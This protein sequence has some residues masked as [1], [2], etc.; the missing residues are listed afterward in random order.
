MSI[1]DTHSFDQRLVLRSPIYSLPEFNKNFEVETLVHDLVFLEAIYI[2]SPSLH[3]ACIKYRDGKI[4]SEKDIIKF[5]YSLYKY[6]SRMHN[7]CTP[8]GLFS[9]CRLT[10]WKAGASE[11][12]IDNYD[13]RRHTRLDMQYLCKL[14]EYLSTLPAIKNRLLY[15]PNSSWYAIGEEIRYV[16][17]IYINGRRQHQ[18]SSLKSST[19]LL[20]IIE[21][22]K[23][24]LGNADLIS[25]LVKAGIKSEESA[26]FIENCMNSQLL[27]NELDPAVTGDGLLT[28]ILK[29]LNS[30]TLQDQ[31][32]IEIVQTLNKIERLLEELDEQ[33][34]NKIDSY[35]EILKLIDSIGLP[36]EEGKIFQTDVTGA[37]TAN[38][39]LSVDLQADILTALDVLHK[40][41]K[42]NTVRLKLFAKRFY[43][44]YGDKEMPLLK[45]LDTEIGIGYIP[46]KQ[47]IPSPILDNITLPESVDNQMH[48]WGKWESILQKKW[49]RAYKNDDLYIEIF[50]EDIDD[51]VSADLPLPSSLQMM[52]EITSSGQVYIENNGGT[53][54]VN[55]LARFAQ[56]DADINKLVT[57]I[58]NNEQDN[59]SGAILAE[60]V[61]LPEG[62]IGNILQRPA[63][64]DYEIP[65]LAKSLLPEDHQICMQ[66]LFISYRN[67]RIVLY[68]KKLNKIILPRLSNAHNFNLNALPVYYF[69]CDLQD[70]D[71]ISSLKFSWGSLHRQYHFLPRVVY[72][73]I[74][75]R[76]ASWVFIEKEILVLLQKDNQLFNELLLWFIKEYNL[77]QKVVLAEGDNELMIDFKDLK[78]THDIFEH[79]LKGKKYFVFKEFLESAN[80]VKDI[81][82]QHYK[83]QFQAFLTTDSKHK[84][85]LFAKN[86]RSWQ[87]KLELGA[88]SDDSEWLYYK[89]YCGIANADL[90]LGNPVKALTSYCEKKGW[91]EEWFFIRYTD[92][93]FHIRLRLKLTD[94]KWLPN[95][96]RIFHKELKPYLKIG[97]LWKVTTDTY[98]P[99]YVRYG[100][101]TVAL[102]EKFFYRDSI[103]FL[104]FLDH[105]SGDERETIRWQF[106]ILS[107]DT[108]FEAFEFNNKCKF[109]LMKNLKESF[110]SEFKF[111]IEQRKQLAKLFRKHK[112]EI[113]ASLNMQQPGDKFYQLYL[114][115]RQRTEK[116]NPVVQQLRI[117]A[118]EG[119]LDVSIVDLLGSYIHMLINR[120]IPD[121]GRL[122]EVVIYDFLYQYYN[123]ID[124]RE[125]N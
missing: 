75:L 4:S 89:L 50:D 27:V 15:F 107:I 55:L 74:I 8:F 7:R 118:E 47:L 106:A 93:N 52:F 114:V 91:I 30:Y 125:N 22:A 24:G 31:Q 5:K 58:T 105:T 38:S 53:S 82:R 95:I 68:S 36:Y 10:K 117:M 61:H 86:D 103:A 32:V 112:D 81:E 44:R 45:V 34:Y 110:A 11:I 41:S 109:E 115:L 62:R 98:Q 26:L 51:I 35:N 123:T 59:A 60:I 79:T 72:K 46:D 104:G 54:A 90:I 18:I 116:I 64:R 9:S 20:Q 3:N 43:E 119:V 40:I 48:R 23:H 49:L 1:K 17:Y 69:L 122:H 85:K 121:L 67:K 29:T 78:T 6:Y 14:V 56:S 101:N 63:F 33:K 13:L 83:H 57:D 102:A 2:A 88:S 76:R 12:T 39:G 19:Y 96:T 37:T 120:I 28:Q 113:Y 21:A 65:Y 42:Q 108:L 73:N 94:V 16:E 66:D 100:T 80:V 124:K 111:G 25:V 71:Q 70:Q 99:E 77:P 97:F 92:N 84:M 87:G